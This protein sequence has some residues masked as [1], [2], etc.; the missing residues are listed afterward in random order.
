MN[1]DLE[2]RPASEIE[3]AP[4][5]TAFNE[6]QLQVLDLQGTHPAHLATFFHQVRRTGLDPFARQIYLITR[7]GNPTIQTG[8]DGFRVIARRAVDVS[9]EAL[10]YGET[11][12]A[13]AKGEW[14]DVWLQDG[15]PAAAK[16]TVYRNG[17]PF[18]AV[19]LYSEYVA[20]RRDG[21]PNTFW[22]NKAALMLA[23]C[24][25]AL[26]LR[27]AFPQDLSGLY[28]ADEM[29]QAG[30]PEAVEY[31]ARPAPSIQRPPAPQTPPQ[32]Q[33][34]TPAPAPAVS[35]PS[36][37]QAQPAPVEPSPA[38]VETGSGMPREEIMSIFSEVLGWTDGQCAT[39]VAWFAQKYD[40]TQVTDA[41]ALTAETWEKFV[42]HTESRDE[43][44]KRAES[45]AARDAAITEARTTYEQPTL[46][47]E[48]ID[49][50]LVD[51]N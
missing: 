42:A 10:G 11:M 37:P 45:V 39:M 28:T 18:S 41:N 6:K 26:A 29:Q 5:Q 36:G 1:K 44:Q 3:I 23:K 46:N 24:A 43:F 2:T 51:G 47:G 4:D 34:A 27:K 30:N 21:K 7:Q 32:P 9:G 25:E 13:N 48:V 38:D 40:G 22:Q 17:Q 15:H 20:L 50:E 19:A 8:I 31:A 12:W 49:A 14:V 35:A 33:P 16:V